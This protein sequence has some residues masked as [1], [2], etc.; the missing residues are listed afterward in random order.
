MYCPVVI[1]TPALSFEKKSK[2]RS[3]GAF[4]SPTMMYSIKSLYVMRLYTD[5]DV[6]KFSFVKSFSS[7]HHSKNIRNNAT[8]SLSHVRIKECKIRSIICQVNLNF[9]R[10]SSNY[11]CDTIF[12]VIVSFLNE[13]VRGFNNIRNGRAKSG[14]QMIK[15]RRL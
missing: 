8:K 3:S 11:I 7:Q 6:G 4:V 13:S 9:L 10:S 14:L 2:Q 5:N 15:F 1:I 12:A